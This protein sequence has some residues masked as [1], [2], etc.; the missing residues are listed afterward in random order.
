MQES[1]RCRTSHN[2]LTFFPFAGAFARRP[3][4][5]S[6]PKYGRVS[7]WNNFQLHLILLTIAVLEC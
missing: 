7:R 2:E 5:I 1:S 4:E 6:L 3:I